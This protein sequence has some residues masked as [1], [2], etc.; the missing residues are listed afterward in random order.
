MADQLTH[1]TSDHQGGVQVA[2]LVGVSSEVGTLRRVMLHRP[3][4]ELKRL[5]PTNKDSLLFDDVLWVKRARQ[6]HDVFADTLVEAGVEVLYLHELLAETLAIPA[7]RAQLID[8]MLDASGHGQHFTRHLRA[9][10][11]ELDPTSLTEVSIAGATFDELPR[12]GSSLAA[13]VAADDD[14]VLAPLPNHLFTRDTSAWIYDG[15]DG[16]LDGQAGPS[17]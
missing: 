9:W 10:L 13:Q 8:G 16:E 7:A 1:E 5:T 3:G 2:P 11:G 14:F 17:S 12:L 15:V 4:N 6:E